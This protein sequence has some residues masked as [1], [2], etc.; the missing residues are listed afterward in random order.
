MQF[1]VQSTP[2]SETIFHY[3]ARTTTYGSAVR[4]VS[5]ALMTQ[6]KLELKLVDVDV[7]A[8]LA[9]VLDIVRTRGFSGWRHKDGESE[10]YGGFSLTYN[11]DHQDGL[12]PHVSTIGTP[13]NAP[14]EFFW[15]TTGAHQTPKHSYFDTYGFRARTPASREGALGDFLDTF[16]RSMVRSRVGIIVG[17]NIDPT[18]QTYRDNAGWHRDELVFENVRVNIPL[19][20]DENFVFQMENEKP[21]HLDVGK[22]YTWDTNRPHRVFAIGPSSTTRIHLVLGFSPWFDYDAATDMWVQNEFF[23]RVHP[24]EIV[25]SGALS[26]CIRMA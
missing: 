14:N 25:A 22:A 5:S 11:P 7:A 6:S 13:K 24:F 9:S 12:D 26:P 15:N 2:S 21:Y 19:Q 3:L 4:Q 1:R 10:R 18:D 16:R 23:G 8:L 20:T 17:K